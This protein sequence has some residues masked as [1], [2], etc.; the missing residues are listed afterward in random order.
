MNN[1]P[2][3]DIT[4]K[5]VGECRNTVYEGEL[6]RQKEI[7]ASSVDY[8]KPTRSVPWAKNRN[9]APGYLGGHV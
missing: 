2:D 9:E 4:G 6:N 7:N 8:A 5:C 1:I 3:R